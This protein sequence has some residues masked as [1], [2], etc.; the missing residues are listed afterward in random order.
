[1]QHSCGCDHDYDRGCKSPDCCIGERC[2]A[3]EDEPECATSAGHSWGRL[4]TWSLGGTTYQHRERC[5]Q[6]G[7]ARIQIV[8]GT[9]RNPGECDVVSY[10]R[11]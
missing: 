3:V 1:M 11:T 8:R 9:Q 5:G 10:D 4:E 6:C 2:A 7:I